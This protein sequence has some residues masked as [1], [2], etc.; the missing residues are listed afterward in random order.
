MERLRKRREYERERYHKDLAV[1]EKKIKYQCERRKTPEYRQQFNKYKRERY[2]NDLSVREK[3][4]EY[5]RK[6]MTCSEHRKKKTE[7][8]N[9]YYYKCRRALN[10]NRLF[11]LT[12]FLNQNNHPTPDQP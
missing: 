10:E 5:Q 1:R 8:K 12:L 2:H 4:S 6:R 11:R 3:V 9:K 7:L